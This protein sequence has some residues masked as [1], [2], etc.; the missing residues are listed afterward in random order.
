VNRT[1]CSLGP[2]G[3]LSRLDAPLVP[4]LSEPIVRVLSGEA[5]RLADVNRP[6]GLEF[7]DG[8]EYLVVVGLGCKRPV[9]LLARCAVRHR[10]DAHAAGV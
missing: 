7:G 6:G 8:V 9:V 10:G 2:S 1:G 5:D 4:E 3:P